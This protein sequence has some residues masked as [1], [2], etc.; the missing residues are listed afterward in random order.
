[1]CGEKI[2]YQPA[3]ALFGAGL[4]TEKSDFRRPGSGIQGCRNTSLFHHRAKIRFIRRPILRFP[5]PFEEFGRRSQ[6]WLM[7]VFNCGN[8]SQE[9][10]EIRMLGE[11]RKLADAILADVNDL[12]NMRAH[13]QR[14]KL[15]CGFPGEADGTEKAL[16]VT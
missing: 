8:F 14:K 7:G 5:I 4:G 6:L 2:R 13:Q 15:L 1:M 12:F 3:V 9:K 16:H 11:P 10:R